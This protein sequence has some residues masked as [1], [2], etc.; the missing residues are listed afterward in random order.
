MNIHK[1]IFMVGIISHHFKREASMLSIRK[2]YV[3]I[4]W[5][6]R[7]Y[8]EILEQTAKIANNLHK[9]KQMTATEMQSL[10]HHTVL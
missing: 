2:M 10:Y 6:E 4:S 5:M 8:W 1:K 9:S 7:E 3:F